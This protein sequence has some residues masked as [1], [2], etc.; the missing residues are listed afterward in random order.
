M[1]LSTHLRST[2]PDELE[3]DTALAFL[4]L[5]TGLLALE[6]N[7]TAQLLFDT[8]AKFRARSTD[9][10]LVK[11]L[12]LFYRSLHVDGNRSELDNMIE[13]LDILNRQMDGQYTAG[14]LCAR[15]ALYQEV[16]EY[17]LAID[18]LKRA[19]ARSETLGGLCPAG[20]IVAI[21]WSARRLNDATECLSWLDAASGFAQSSTCCSLRYRNARLLAANLNTKEITEP[22]IMEA[23]EILPSLES[24]TLVARWAICL[25]HYFATPAGWA[26]ETKHCMV[27]KLTKLIDVS[28]LVRTVAFE[29]DLAYFDLVALNALDDLGLSACRQDWPETS[30]G[31]VQTGNIQGVDIDKI[32][33]A[34]IATLFALKERALSLDRRL[35]SSKRTHQIEVRLRLMVKVCDAK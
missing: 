34:V 20:L 2:T 33:K 7:E 18:A 19:W 29:F 11:Q 23:I 25:L 4:L 16:G 35:G 31:H 26:I 10:N 8:Q 30:N 5:M 28:R 24:P 32:P 6:V 27:S 21:V 3:S 12:A 13:E 15:A 1:R 9:L 22:E 14:V 17:S